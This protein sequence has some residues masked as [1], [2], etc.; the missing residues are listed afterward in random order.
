MNILVTVDRNYLSQLNIMLSSLVHCNPQSF[1]SVY[2]LHSSLNVTDV[3]ETE[4]VL[5]NHGRLI[6]IQ[7]TDDGLDN[8][9]ITDRYPKEIYYRIF[10]AKYLPKDIDRILYLDP[11]IVIN[12]SLELLYR[13]PLDRYYYAATSHNSKW[14]DKFN[15]ARL[16]IKNEGYY[17]NSG[18]LMINLKA[19]R[20]EQDYDRVFRFIEDKKKLLVLP[21]QD[22]ISGLYGD[23]VYPINPLLYNMTE[24]LYKKNTISEKRISLEWVRENS[25]IIHYC[26]RNK[27]WNHKYIGKL[28]VFYK[29]A[30][31]RMHEMVS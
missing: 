17:I 14:F 25:R 27:P 4:K 12:G 28:D 29:E 8:A 15:A 6:P 7:V 2:L 26:G 3:A 1:F 9:P 16:D 18:V 5:G 20:E 31:Q 19:L 10:A 11:D 24:T 22:V 23:K 13:L 30:V 21:D